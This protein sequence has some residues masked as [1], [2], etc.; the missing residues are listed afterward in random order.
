MNKRQSS[1]TMKDVAREAG[2]SLGTV[3]NVF[4]GIPVG[5]SYKKRVEKAA[6]KLNYKLNAPARALKTN[7]TNCIAI[8][9]PTL[10][11]PFF[12]SLSDELI[13]CLT[14]KGYRNNL[15]ITNYDSNAEKNAIDLLTQHKIDGIIGLTYN[16]DLEID[17][18]IP[19]ITIDRHLNRTVP[20]VS[21]DNFGGGQLAADK[22]IDLGCKNLLFF[23]IDSDIYGEVHKRGPG[24]EDICNKRGV[25]YRSVIL[26][27][28]DTE[29]P[30]Y[31]YLVSHIKDGKPEYDGIF[32]NSDLLA[33]HVKDF[34]ESKDINVPETVQIIGYDGIPSFYKGKLMCSTIVQPIHDMAEAAVDLVLHSNQNTP[35]AFVNLPV[36]YA[37]GGTTKE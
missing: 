5:E 2:V 11:H 37:P 34:L 33:V 28:T 9:M 31:D 26:N 21:S 23:R 6:L 1:P 27:N 22:L 20:C 30:F 10:L 25:N 24:F 4:N 12:A 16:Q 36:R 17:K 29:A 7:R 32:C 19:F 14:K 8:L 13:A 18:T 35:P 15:I 3:S